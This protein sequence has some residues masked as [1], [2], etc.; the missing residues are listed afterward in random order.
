MDASFGVATG[1]AIAAPNPKPN[2]CSNCA[3]DR[4]AALRGESRERL[5]LVVRMA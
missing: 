4:P 5:L 2:G 3:D 1:G